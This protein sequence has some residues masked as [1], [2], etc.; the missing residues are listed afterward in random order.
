MLYTR[1]GD[2]GTTKTFGCNQ[3]LSKSSAIAEALGALDEVNSYLG[4][5]RADIR[6]RSGFTVPVG[7]R[8]KPVE[9]V[10]H[11]VQ[12]SLFTIQAEVAGAPKKVTK[13]KVT[14]LERITDSIEQALPPIHT[15]SFAGG[16]YLSALFD[17]ARTLA[18]KAERRV[19]AVHDEEVQPVSTHTR[20]Y[21][22]RLSSALFALARYANHVDDVDEEAPTY[23]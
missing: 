18:R 1:K 17:V 15:F 6:G 3:C 10:L 14:A 2:K 11:A 7:A 19:I 20:A 4:L 12:E 13:A 5:C 23:R 22:N 9:A 8:T 21:L 16:T